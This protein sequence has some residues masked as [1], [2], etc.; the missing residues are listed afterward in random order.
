M[1]KAIHR[2]MNIAAN[3]AVKC[4]YS[5]LEPQSFF[6]LGGTLFVPPAFLVGKR[7]YA[8]AAAFSL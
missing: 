4:L 1:N 7:P 3:I 5:I 6:C 8:V 2:I